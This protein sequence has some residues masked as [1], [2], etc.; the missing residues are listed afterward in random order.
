MRNLCLD[1]NKA[2]QTTE[3]PLFAC[4]GAYVGS[5]IL[6]CFF[7]NGYG[8]ALQIQEGGDMKIDNVWIQDHTVSNYAITINDTLSTNT[9]TGIVDIGNIY[10][11]NITNSLTGDPRDVVA[12]RANAI[13]A[14][15]VYS[16]SINEI[17]SEGCLTMLTY[18]GAS[19]LLRIGRATC[20][21]YGSGNDTTAVIRFKQVPLTCVVGPIRTYQTETDFRYIY[22]NT[23]DNNIPNQEVNS[24]Y[25]GFGGFTYTSSSASHPVYVD[26]I[27]SGDLERRLYNGATSSWGKAW[28]DSGANS[29]FYDKANGGNWIFGAMKNQSAE[30]PFF[31]LTS[32][33]NAGDYVLFNKPFQVPTL[34]TAGSRTV[35]CFYTHSSSTL[36]R[37]P[38]YQ[39]IAGSTNGTD[40]FATVRRETA[41]PSDTADYVGQLYLNTTARQL[42]V[43]SK[44]GTGSGDYTKIATQGDSLT[45]GAGGIWQRNWYY[46]AA[47]SSIRIVFYNSTLSRIDTVKCPQAN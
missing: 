37:G 19:G 17:H 7:Y 12:D 35:G 3:Q 44:F 21:W 20:S 2:N 28:A 41:A 15:K 33:G 23:A 1:G 29:Y 11:E 14:N 24:T 43:A 34:T 6:D 45:V 16:L 30:T 40:Y 38:V 4:W 5:Y 26:P 25:P 36:G 31:T 39:R 47:D 9:A 22:N 27:I 13:F 10:I 18:A 42:Y 8:P 46:S 32:Y